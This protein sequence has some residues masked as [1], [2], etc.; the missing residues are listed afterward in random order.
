[1]TRQGA[2][3]SQQPQFKVIASKPYSGSEPDQVKTEATQLEI[4][5]CYEERTPGPPKSLQR[6]QVNHR[7][8]AKHRRRCGQR[9]AL[10]P[11]AGPSPDAAGPCD[12]HASRENVEKQ[13]QPHEPQW[14]GEPF[15]EDILTPISKIS[16]ITARKLPGSVAGQRHEQQN[17][18]RER[19]A[20]PKEPTPR[21]CD[22]PRTP[23]RPPD[24]QPG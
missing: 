15:M 9:L 3:A 8:N 7:A 12:E 2:V 4:K 21:E 14:S 17:P 10:C 19:Y 13:E 23:Q 1:M 22:H 6:W 5:W 16:G 11:E 18:D 24:E 20:E